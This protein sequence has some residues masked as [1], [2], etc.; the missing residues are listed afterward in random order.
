M[1][2]STEKTLQKIL[3]VHA[4]ALDIPSG[5]ANS[6]ISHTISAVKKSLQ[7]KSS[8]KTTITDQDLVRLIT[9]ELKKYNTDLA[10]VYQNY[11]TII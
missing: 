11:A 4:R 3:K 6:F 8:S 9:K 5:A 10:Y 7:T 1:D 2:A